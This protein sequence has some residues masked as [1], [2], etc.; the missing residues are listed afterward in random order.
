MKTNK[1]GRRWVKP[2]FRTTNGKKKKV[3]G[4]YKRIKLNVER[5]NKPHWLDRAVEKDK[6]YFKIQVEKGIKKLAGDSTKERVRNCYHCKLW[7]KADKF[8][9]EI[10]EI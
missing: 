3:R 5:E 6:E 1:I 4:Y 10:K 9:K 7:N 2:F 8:I